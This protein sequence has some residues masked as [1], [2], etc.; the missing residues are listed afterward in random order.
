MD[1]VRKKILSILE[2][3]KRPIR[4]FV[5]VFG[6]GKPDTIIPLLRQMLDN[7]E[8]KYKDGLLGV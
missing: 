1:E 8:I 6:F 7:Q 5:D 3:D 2:K 4:Y